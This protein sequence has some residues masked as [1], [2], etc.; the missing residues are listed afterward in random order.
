[1]I[2]PKHGGSKQLDRSYSNKNQIPTSSPKIF[3]NKIATAKIF[4]WKDLKKDLPLII[5]TLFFIAYDV[6]TIKRPKRP[7][8]SNPS[9]CLGCIQGN[10]EMDLLKLDKHNHILKII[11]KKH[12]SPEVGKKSLNIK[13]GK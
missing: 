11:I 3:K 7:H 10:M 4:S 5:F 6:P 8:M 2:K 12:N 13:N 9:S 1:M